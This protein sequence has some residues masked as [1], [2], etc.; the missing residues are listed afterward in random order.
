MGGDVTSSNIY[1]DQI[2][3]CSIQAVW[4]G[5]PTGTIKVQ[6]S[7]DVGPTPEYN[8]NGTITTWTDVTGSSQSIAGAAGNFWW[9]LNDIG[10]RWARLVYTRTSGTGTLDARQNIKGF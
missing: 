10:A 2:F 5:T 7:N 8:P 1:L 6:V 4:T 9:N 3:T